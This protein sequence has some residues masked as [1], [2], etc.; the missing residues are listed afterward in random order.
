[1]YF[2]RFNRSSLQLSTA[3]RAASVR[4]FITSSVAILRRGNCIVKTSCWRVTSVPRHLVYESHELNPTSLDFLRPGSGLGKWVPIGQI[5]G[6]GS[7][8]ACPGRLAGTV[9]RG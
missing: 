6:T 2:A 5:V 7:K 9:V 4:L 8:A 3:S 1:M